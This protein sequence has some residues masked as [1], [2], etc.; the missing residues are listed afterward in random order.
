MANVAE[1]TDRDAG[2]C[3][4]VTIRTRRVQILG[5][6]LDQRLSRVEPPGRNTN[7]EETL[8]RLPGRGVT[9]SE[10]VVT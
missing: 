5:C 2:P 10:I 1:T 8:S 4:G 9:D 3:V 7:R 6:P